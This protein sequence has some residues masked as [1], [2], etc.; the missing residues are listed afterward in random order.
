VLSRDIGG[1]LRGILE[2]VAT[3]VAGRFGFSIAHV[4]GGPEGAPEGGKNMLS[5]SDGG[6]RKLNKLGARGAREKER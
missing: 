4:L 6:G 2:E 3:A 1:G 5:T